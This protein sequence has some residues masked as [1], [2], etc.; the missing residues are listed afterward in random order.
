MSSKQRLSME[1]LEDLLPGDVLL[2][3]KQEVVIKP[4][5]IY[6]LALVSRKL[7]SFIKEL[8]EDG[9]TLDNCKEPENIIDIASELFERFPDVLAEAAD[10]HEEDVK[11]LPINIIVMLLDKVIE[12]NMKSNDSFMG[13]LNGLISKVMPKQ[14]EE[15]PQ[16]K[17]GR[18]R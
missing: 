11:Q 17:K 14:V 15:Q 3:G 16:K 12:V 9:I 2:I 18:R 10:I 1:T 4:L 5:G 7:K 8:K 6:R 13:N